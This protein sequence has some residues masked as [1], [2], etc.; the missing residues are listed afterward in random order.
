MKIMPNTIYMWE[1]IAQ[2]VACLIPRSN[3]TPWHRTSFDKM[4]QIGAGFLQIV[5]EDR[6]GHIWILQWNLERW[7][8]YTKNL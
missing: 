5:L 3:A 4:T 7:N 1:G 8:L 2:K 6:V